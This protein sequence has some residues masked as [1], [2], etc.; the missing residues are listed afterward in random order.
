MRPRNIFLLPSLLIF[1]GGQAFCE[2]YFDPSLLA[3]AGID[4]GDIDLSIFSHPGGGI[5]GEREV[6]VWVN[7]DFYTRKTLNFR[8]ATEKGL[9]PDFPA[10][11]FDDLLAPEYRPVQKDALLSS[12]D[13]MSQTPYSSV[14]FNQGEGRVDIRV[15]QAFLGRAAQLRSS[16]DTWENGVPALLMDYSLTGNR[17]DSD[18][19]SSRSLY[20]SARLGLN[21]GPWR[22]RTSGNY[23][24]YQSESRWWRSRTENTSFYSTWLERD[25][26]ALRASLRIGEVSTGGMILDSVSFRGVRLYSNDD[27]LSSRLRNYSPTVK[28]FART[29]AVVIITQ[30]GRQVYQTN[31][32][33]GPF[34]LNDFYISGYSGDLVVTVRESDGSEHSF[35]QPFSTL[36]EMKREGVSGFELSAG[37]YDNHG[38]EDYYNDP[39]F[40]YGAWSRGFGGGVTV[41]GET[42]QAGKYQSAGIGSTLSLGRVGAVSA[43]ISV[44][45]AEKYDDIHTGQ[46]Y[47]L[48]YSKSQVETGTTVT[49]ATYRYSTKDFYS[50]GDFLSRTEQAHYVWENRLKNRMTLS[51]NQSLGELGALSLSASHQ[52][53]WTTGKVNRTFSLSHSFNWKDFYFSTTFSMDQMKG[54]NYSYN[55]NRQV[56]F[57]VSIPLSSLPGLGEST[58]TSISWGTTR[59]NHQLRHSTTLT[60]SVPDTRM[61]YRVGSSW[62]NAGASDGTSASLAWNSDFTTTSLGYTRS[63]GYRTTDFSLSGSAVAWSGGVAFGSNSV[64]DN[65][66]IVVN[67]SGVSGIGTSAGGRTTWPGTALISSPQLYTENRIDLRTDSLPDDIVLAETSARTVPSR[68][69]VVVL[70]YTVYRG[71]Q[72]VF[73]L[74]RPDGS[75]LPFGA[76]VSL[77]GMPSG[78]ENTGIV[79]DEGRVYLAGVP[80]KGRL[81]VSSGGKQCHVDFVLPQDR[82]Q[83]GPVADVV[84]LCR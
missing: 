68:G 82:K 25:I 9:L 74:K 63:G 84:A 66:A 19:Y 73:S 56:D 39:L 45:R 79:G 59:T 80:E 75:V 71:G 3:A 7:D 77:D 24:Q 37:R 46:S 83:T 16:P 26:S 20:A 28:G 6:S 78:K 42:L 27:M 55:D 41:F 15:P 22:L 18:D 2:D 67:T 52:D 50:F 64:A 23:S 31:V 5:E 29:Q 30:N 17:N 11:F 13:F 49:L 58:S 43:D 61:R 76:V 48:K 44:S 33:A 57:H 1:V 21:V 53:Y 10:G 69:A 32:P 65:G 4:G 81:T 40:V 36:P 38:S 60:G 54:H 51:L 62:G 34:E 8:N 35:I 12:A 47:G 14:I 70:D 72:V